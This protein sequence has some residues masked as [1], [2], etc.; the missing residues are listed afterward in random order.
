MCGG[1]TVAVQAACSCRPHLPFHL[2]GSLQALTQASEYRPHLPV[3]C[4][5]QRWPSAHVLS[6]GKHCMDPILCRR[7]MGHHMWPAMQGGRAA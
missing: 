6:A 3:Q 1:S 4:R 2:E 5:V 7:A